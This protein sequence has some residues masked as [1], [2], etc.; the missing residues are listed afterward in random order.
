MT[1][2][3]GKSERSYSQVTLN[4]CS[5]CGH[6]LVSEAN[7]CINCGKA[8]AENS[9]EV[10]SYTTNSAPIISSSGLSNAI[11]KLKIMVRKNPIVAILVTVAITAILV[12]VLV[13][14]PSS[15]NSVSA[16]SSSGSSK[17]AIEEV[18]KQI[19]Y[20]L[21]DEYGKK[22]VKSISF[23]DTNAEETAY[24]EKYYSVTGYVDYQ[25]TWA[26]TPRIDKKSRRFS[27]YVQY[28]DGEW[29]VKDP[30]GDNAPKMYSN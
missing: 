8:L 22:Y 11:N 12:S 9:I 7:F 18:K 4:Y 2:K 3:K 16:L 13:G 28:R 30:R 27:Y 1:N 6:K 14:G 15:T 25:L 10:E 20:S 19:T 24:G 26:N 23:R 21:E 17:S 29:T 5:D